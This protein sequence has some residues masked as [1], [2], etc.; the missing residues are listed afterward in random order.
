[1]AWAKSGELYDSLKPE[2]VYDPTDNFNVDKLCAKCS[3]KDGSKRCKDCQ[4]Y[5]GVIGSKGQKK[6]GQLFFS[7]HKALRLTFHD[8]LKYKDGG[9]GC[10]GCL[11]FDE[12]LDGN[13][14]LQHSVAILVC[15]LFV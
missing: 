12:N 4:C 11:N 3:C 5:R 8:C 13:N 10:D 9:M 7:P 2:D 1:M 15:K 6:K 14:G